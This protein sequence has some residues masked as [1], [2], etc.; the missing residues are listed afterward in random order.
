MA[1]SRTP[2][3]RSGGGLTS[4]KLVRPKISAGSRR[5]NAISPSAVDMMGQQT[6]FKKPDLIKAQPRDF[7]PLGNDLATNVGKGGPG[8][9]RT[10]YPCGYQ[11]QHGSAAPGQRGIEGRA[12]RGHRAILGPQS[13]NPGHHEALPKGQIRRGQQSGE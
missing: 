8:T 4:N 2:K 11:D 5:V 6:S 10:T 3:V 13:G 12:D 7:V 9:G 1:K